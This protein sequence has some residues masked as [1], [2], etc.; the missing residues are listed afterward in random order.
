MTS[1]KNFLAIL[2]LSFVVYA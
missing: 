1:S 2:L